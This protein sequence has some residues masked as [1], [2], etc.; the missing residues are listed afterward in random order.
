M[1]RTFM[2]KKN[3]NHQFLALM[4]SVFILC[5]QLPAWGSAG[6][7]ET[8]FYT[9][10]GDM[11][12]M[13][14]QESKR[15]EIMGDNLFRDYGYYENDLGGKFIVGQDK[16]GKFKLFDRIK[17]TTLDF[18]NR[19]E[20][21]KVVKSNRLK[22]NSNIQHPGLRKLRL[23]TDL[24]I[25]NQINRYDYY[26][27]RYCLYILVPFLGLLVICNGF[28]DRFLERDLPLLK[29]V[30][31]ILNSNFFSVPVT[32]L[33]IVFNLSLINGYYSEYFVFSGMFGLTIASCIAWPLARKSLLLVDSS[34]PYIEH[35]RKKFSDSQLA[36]LKS[37]VFLG[38]L[39]IIL[40]FTIG[41][42]QAPFTSEQYF[43]CE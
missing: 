40:S 42:C 34:N 36:Y 30:D 28:I 3:I 7:S 13:D 5:H 41:S 31:K 37:F 15:V 32:I 9:P 38:S 26:I 39:M 8:P 10:E 24:P 33:S 18:P 12:G 4:F 29:R 20:L 25:V 21:C 35:F 23:D 16:D 6:F 1:N 2:A 14:G 17:K 19:T 22:L 27:I 43:Y 11:F